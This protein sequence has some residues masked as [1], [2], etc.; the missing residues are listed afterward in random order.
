MSQMLPSNYTAHINESLYTHECIFLHISVSHV[1]TACIPTK[2]NTQMSQDIHTKSDVTRMEKSRH[3]VYLPT[4][5]HAQM[6]HG[7][8]MNELWHTNE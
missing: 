1:I 8:H 3:I 5:P 4:N 6:S 7:T 2:S